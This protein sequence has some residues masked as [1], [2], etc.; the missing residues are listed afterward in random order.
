MTLNLF[1]SEAASNVGR[2]FSQCYIVFAFFPRSS[3][4]MM[5]CV[6]SYRLFM[7]DKRESFEDTISQP[8]KIP[9]VIMSR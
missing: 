5:I 9:D 3:N 2:I 7:S 6:T 1:V 4:F 8:L